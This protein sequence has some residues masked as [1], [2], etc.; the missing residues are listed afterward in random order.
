M[1]HR[2]WDIAEVFRDVAS[3]IPYEK[4]CREFVGYGALDVPRQGVETR[5]TSVKEMNI[6]V[7][8]VFDVWYGI[9]R[10]LDKISNQ[11]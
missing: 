3:V 5:T 6:S 7:E 9:K 2:V 11:V 10:N 8:I 1:I 4:H